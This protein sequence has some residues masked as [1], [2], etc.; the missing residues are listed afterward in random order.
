MQSSAWMKEDCSFLRTFFRSQI[1]LFFAPA[2]HKRSAIKIMAGDNN[3]CNASAFIQCYL[4]LACSTLPLPER[5][6]KSSRPDF[7]MK[8]KSLTTAI[9]ILHNDE[10]T[11]LVTLLLKIK[12]RLSTFVWH[13]FV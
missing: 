7:Y 12:H 8:Q 6:G 3:A 5:S 2:S 9:K 13:T 10:A 11:V 1:S 4:L